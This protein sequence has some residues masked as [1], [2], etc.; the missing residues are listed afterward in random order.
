MI[1]SQRTIEIMREYLERDID[2]AHLPAYDPFAR[3]L[4]AGLDIAKR[5]ALR[6]FDILFETG[7]EK[8][9]K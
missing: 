7:F 2:T 1:I 3:G 4:T 5:N 6:L 8:A 9:G